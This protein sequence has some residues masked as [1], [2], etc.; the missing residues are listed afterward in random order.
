MQGDGLTNKNKLQFLGLG[1]RKLVVLS[2]QYID[3]LYNLYKDKYGKMIKKKKQVVLLKLMNGI[4]NAL[5]NPEITK[6]TDFKD[7]DRDDIIKPECV[8]VYN[9]MEDEL[10]TCFDKHVCSWYKRKKIKNYIMTFIRYTCID[11][12][13]K[14]IYKKRE[15]TIIVNNKRYKGIHYMYSIV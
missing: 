9:Q 7:I 6:L 4:L 10:F 11:I 8:S 14:Y 15:T 5:G 2:D 3:D 1:S 13:L 12:G